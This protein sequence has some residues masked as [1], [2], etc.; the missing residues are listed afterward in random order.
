MGERW[1]KEAEDLKASGT[2]GQMLR[3]HN[4]PKVTWHVTVSHPGSFDMVHRVLTSKKSEPHFIYDPKTDR[5]GQYFPLD[6]GAR[7]LGNDGNTPTNRDGT[8]NIQIEVVAMPGDIRTGAKG[9]TELPYF[10]A[11]APNFRAMM[12]AIRS[13]GVP[14]V[15]TSDVARGS[16]ADDSVSRSWTKY[17]KAGHTGHCAVPGNSHWDPGNIDRD[18]IFGSSVKSQPVP[19]PATRKAYTTADVK[20]FQNTIGVKADGLYGDNTLRQAQAVRR[21]VKSGE[22]PSYWDRVRLWRLKLSRTARGVDS[23]SEQIRRG[24]QWSLR[25][26]VDGDFG[27]KTQ[28]AFDAM[29]DQKHN[30]F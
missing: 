25:V 22:K 9:F 28:A 10:D 16:W 13:W 21:C 14:D 2:S 1:V 12:R 26:A 3:N 19:T 27:P 11:D 8:I 6:R 20:R 23:S 17:R 24:I 4:N 18:A 29:I 30:K 5:L 15:W 7:A